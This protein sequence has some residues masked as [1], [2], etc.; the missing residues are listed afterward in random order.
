MHILSL[1]LLLELILESQNFI[2]PLLNPMFYNCFSLTRVNLQRIQTDSN[3][4]IS[5]M[6]YNCYQLE[7]YIINKKYKINMIIFENKKIY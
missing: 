7:S 2:S 1:E 6:F 4:D 3:I 5:F